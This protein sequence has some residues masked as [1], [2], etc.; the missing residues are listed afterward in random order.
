MRRRLMRRADENDAAQQML[1]FTEDAPAKGNDEAV[2]AA[3]QGL[4]DA[5]RVILQAMEKFK[6]Q[7]SQCAR[8]TAADQQLSRKIEQ[9][10]E[11]VDKAMSALYGVCFSLENVDL[12]PVY[13]ADQVQFGDDLDYDLAEDVPLPEDDEEQEVPDESED[14]EDEGEGGPEGGPEGGG[15]VGVPAEAP[16]EDAEE[17]EE[18]EEAE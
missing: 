2:A 11:I 6:Y 7:V 1:G 13:D 5:G 14:G 4:S 18:S 8:L 12:T 17:P 16:A 3:L 15:D 10:V 9:H